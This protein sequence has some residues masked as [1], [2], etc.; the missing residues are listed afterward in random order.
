MTFD[1]KVNILLVDDQPAKLLSYEVMLAGLG[2]NLIK[3]PSANEALEVLLKT[4]IAVLLIDVCMPELDGFELAT[5]IRE[6]PRFQHIAIIFI[7]AIYLSEMDHLR[8]YSTG[9]VDYVPVP[10]VPEVLRA[11][12]RVFSELH[13]KT[14]QLEELNRDLERRVNERT[15]AAEAS[16]SRLQRS[17]RGRS[18]ALAAGNMGSWEYDFTTSQWFWDEGQ[19][20]IFGVAFDPGRFMPTTENIRPFIL[21]KDW[22]RLSDALAQA[23]PANNTFQAE[24][25]MVRANGEERTCLV[26]AAATFDALGTLARVDG[27][28]IDITE[29]KEAE[30]RQVLLAREV[31]HRAR[32]ALAIVQ[33][34][35]RLA[36]A[37]S[38]EDYIRAIEGRIRALAQAHELLSQSRWQGADMSSLVT[39]EMAPYMTDDGARVI[40]TGSTVLLPADKAQTVA[41]ALHE[42]ATNAAKYGALSSPTGQVRIEWQ[43]SRGNLVLNWFESGGPPVTEK[44]SSRGFGTK[45]IDASIHPRNGGATK[46]DWRKEGLRCMLSIP[47]VQPD[48]IKP[49]Q[50]PPA[51]NRMR[52]SARHILLVEDEGIVGMLMRTFLEETG[53]DVTG[54]VATLNDALATARAQVFGGAVL[55]INLG[56]EPVYPLAELLSARAIPFVFATGYNGDGVDS[57]FAHIP[58]LQKPIERDSLD[59]AL[60]SAMAGGQAP[61]RR[62]KTPVH[63]EET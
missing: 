22:Q 40:M 54:P 50:S 43:I 3:V 42:L 23:T 6:H 58:T 55:D 10:V 48:E 26:V 27:V 57:R 9:A 30:S 1:N 25:R 37:E 39:E 4:D 28:T 36:R 24:L 11:K 2:E 45:I 46:F 44:P 20:G 32:N 61:K 31:D 38:T 49:A 29:R 21:E 19:R 7:S 59:L 17:E 8:G 62:P 35:V 60:Q 52:G 5:M 47:V 56:G 16:A 51:S 12:V 18:L 41:L 63:S 33:A 53:Y 34:I 14:R 15:A 13:R